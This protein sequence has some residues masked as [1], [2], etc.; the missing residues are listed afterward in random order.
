MK[1]LTEELF[2]KKNTIIWS[3]LEDFYTRIQK[4]S[5]KS[6]PS[7]EIK[8][9]L[10]LFKLSSHDLAYARTH[11]PKSSTENY[12]NSL[13]GR[14]NHHVYAV[15]K[16]SIGELLQ[17]FS[18]GFPKLLK[19]NK[20][21][22]SCSFVFFALGFILS[23]IM[24]LYNDGNAALFLP[25]DMIDGIKSGKMGDGGWNYPLMSSYIM[26]NNISVSLRAFVFGI[27]LGLGTIYVLFFNGTMLGALTALVYLYSKPLEYWSLILPHGIIELTAIFIS[28][29]A[30][31]IIARSILLPC[32]LTRRHS[33]VRGAKKAVSLVPGIIL[34]LIAAGII[35]G[36]FTPLVISALWKLIFAAITLVALAIY[37]LIP[38]VTR[39]ATT[40]S[41]L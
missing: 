11:F 38:Y 15:R 6:M 16:F 35:E 39:T 20:W 14:C 28:G 26:T 22:I 24:V 25:G 13:V 8:R 34:M 31:L 41:Q 40:R 1:A 10:H 4:K 2:I 23:L 36:F 29:G 32:D 30:G 12:L 33:L 19:E 17:Y 3:E 5:L 37:F 21:Y 18:S 27:T 7:I 9:F